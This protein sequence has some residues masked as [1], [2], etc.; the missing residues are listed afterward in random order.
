MVVSGTTTM[1]RFRRAIDYGPFDLAALWER[2]FAVA[3]TIV[4]G[5]N[6]RSVPKL[7]MRRY[8]IGAGTPLSQF[9]LMTHH[10]LWK[11]LS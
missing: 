9:K 3:V 6:D 4:A 7:E 5:P 10:V 8:C 1:L 11:L 2:Q